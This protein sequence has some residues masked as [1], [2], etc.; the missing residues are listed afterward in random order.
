MS[1]FRY[2]D[3]ESS[4]RPCGIRCQDFKRFLIRTGGSDEKN[5]LETIFEW[6]YFG[7]AER[8][9]ENKC[10][11]W[12]D[13]N[14]FTDPLI[15][16][17]VHLQ[18]DDNL[19]IYQLFLQSKNFQKEKGFVTTQFGRLE[20]HLIP[21]N[22]CFCDNCLQ[23]SLIPLDLKIRIIVFKDFFIPI[24]GATLTGLAIRS[25]IPPVE[26]CQPNPRREDFL[27]LGDGIDPTSSICGLSNSRRTI[28][29]FS[30]FAGIVSHARR[31]PEEKRLMRS[32]KP[33]TVAQ[34][35]DELFLHIPFLLMGIYEQ[36]LYIFT[37]GSYIILVRNYPP[38]IEQYFKPSED[39]V[40]IY[41]CHG[42]RFAM[43]TFDK[44]YQEEGCPIWG[45]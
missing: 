42:Q 18:G 41:R 11:V 8:D 29:N 10:T 6:L 7:D 45:H 34:N 12:V 24:D 27:W 28:Q 9:F 26:C 21:Y 44:D 38:K 33:M 1:C 39:L 37:T 22:K 30:T 15:Q 23:K 31:N 36:Q 20:F 4:L 25:L 13:H 43:R 2:L 5:L 19:Y 40:F 16:L 17:F 35:W 3:L 14:I 32:T